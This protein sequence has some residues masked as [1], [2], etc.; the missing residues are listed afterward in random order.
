MTKIY[1]RQFTMPPGKHCSKCG[2]WKPPGQFYADNRR[3]SG[4]TCRCRL[5]IAAGYAS[6]SDDKRARQMQYWHDKRNDILRRASERHARDRAIVF[7][8][9]GLE[10]LCCGNDSYDELT[11][12]H[13]DGDGPEHRKAIGAQTSQELYRW[14]IKNGFPDRPRLISLC[15]G[16]NSSKRSGDRCRKHDRVLVRTGLVLTA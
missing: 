10:C 9:Y 12:D 4:L 8:H 13:L 5:C 14:L 15:R 6:N 16:C 11:I 3:K 2:L 1:R 7:A